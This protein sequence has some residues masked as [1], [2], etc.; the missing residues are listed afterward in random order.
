MRD[1]R[2]AF[3]HSRCHLTAPT[4]AVIEA[5]R[6]HVRIECADCGAMVIRLRLSTPPVASPE[7]DNRKAE[8]D[9]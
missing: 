9:G 2:E 3:I 7:A 8:N 6:Q 4:W 5:D 1:N